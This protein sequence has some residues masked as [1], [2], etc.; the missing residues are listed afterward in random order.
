MVIAAGPA[1]TSPVKYPSA[2]TPPAPRTATWTETGTIGER[3]APS[4]SHR[5]DNP[6]TATGA[7]PIATGHIEASTSRST[8]SSPIVA[9]ATSSTTSV[10]ELEVIET[11]TSPWIIDPRGVGSTSRDERSTS[12]WTLG[13]LASHPAVTSKRPTA[14][15]RMGPPRATAVPP[16]LVALFAASSE[17][18]CTKLHARVQREECAEKGCRQATGW[19]VAALSPP[20]PPSRSE[21]GVSALGCAQHLDPVARGREWPKAS[22]L[23]PLTRRP[24]VTCDGSP[25][26]HGEGGRG[27]N[28]QPLRCREA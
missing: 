24:A 2:P 10:G 14:K 19:A 25:R 23:R 1:S 16:L 6:A 22:S 9:S 4:R 3:H 20:R 21:G 11:S 13:S 15:L 7:S 26:S 12:T 17:V 18:V 5:M 8:R 27:V 28:W